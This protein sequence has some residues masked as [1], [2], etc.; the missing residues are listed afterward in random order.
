[1]PSTEMLPAAEAE[2]ARSI[3][4]KLN[5]RVLPFV[6]V[7]YII[8]M[9]DRT[10]VSF[11]ALQMNE[12]LGFSK[13]V[14]GFGA[15]IFFLGY[16][17]FEIPSNL[18]LARVGA[19]KWI[20]RILVTWGLFATAMM[21]VSGP[22]SFYTLRFLLGVAEA[23]FLPGILFY[24]SY[25]YPAAQRAH[26]VSWFMI[27][28]PMAQVVGGPIAGLLL[29]LDG[30]LGLHGWQWMYLCE[31]VPAV[32]AG[33]VVLRFMTDSP[34]DAR[35]LTQEQRSWLTARIQSEHAA[36]EQRHGVGLRQALLHPT[37][38][39]LA[40][41]AFAFQTG[42][43]GLQ[44]WTP[45]IVKEWSGLS[46][47]GVG[48]V[49]AIPYIGAAIGM[50]LIGASSDRRGERFMHIAVPSVVAAVGFAASAFL[51]SPVLGIMGLTVAA[52]GC[53]GSR[54]PFWALPG[55]FLTASASAAG[56]ALINTVGSVGGF[57]GPYAVGLAK[58]LTDSYA[59]G[60][61][62][63]SVLLVL[64]AAAVLRLRDREELQ[65]LAVGEAIR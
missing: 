21:F 2:L 45:L 31:G 11:A 18:I 35:W 58:D 39:W 3:I 28:I 8:A 38:W 53:M 9:I 12:D 34:E 63:L 22:M 46:D 41:V 50:V 47:L 24:L 49:S 60:L 15:G 59:A 20:A 10:N 30:A 48:F 42:S 33:F 64:G 55:R 40:F 5:W 25:W 26:A 27:G 36:A 1:M 44:L 19:R 6:L 16:A 37:V 56:L 32:L 62:L 14:Y 29:G 23:G 13:A 65:P 4:S 7:L 54:G 17:L 43:Y 52:V 57:V 51:N 61:I